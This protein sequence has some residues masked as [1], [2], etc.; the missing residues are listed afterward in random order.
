MPSGKHAQLEAEIA[1]RLDAGDLA[2]AAAAMLRGYGV[3]IFGYLVALAR[4]P[5]LADEVFSM[6]SEDLWRGLPGFRRESSARTWL[7]RLAWHAFQRRR[8]DAFDRRRSPLLPAL[9]ELVAEIRSRTAPF[10]RTEVKQAV[11][12]LRDELAPDEQAL[13]I[14]RIDRGLAWREIA[15]VMAAPEATLNKRFERIKDKLRGLAEAAGL[16]AGE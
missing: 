2:A 11:A 10:L 6:V 13:L 15:E 4:D 3:E 8:E 12:R 1:G 16:I 7:Y 5:P 14:L 9:E